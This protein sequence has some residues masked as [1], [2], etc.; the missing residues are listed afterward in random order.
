MVLCTQLEY[1]WHEIDL[2]FVCLSPIFRK[3]CIIK[4]STT[5]MLT[6]FYLLLSPPISPM[7]SQINGYH[8]VLIYPLQVLFVTQQSTPSSSVYTSSVD[9][10]Q[11]AAFTLSHSSVI[12]PLFNS[13]G[14]RILLRTSNQSSIK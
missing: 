5:L 14:F 7:S 1:S 9:Q 11:S 13:L 8:C 4:F 3:Y 6:F 10:S 2:I 12:S